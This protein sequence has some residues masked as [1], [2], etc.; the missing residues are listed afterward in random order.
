MSSSIVFR[1]EDRRQWV[2]K[3]SANGLAAFPLTPDSCLLNSGLPTEL[4]LVFDQ[5]VIELGN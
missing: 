5:P 4:R 1:A 3:D 2:I